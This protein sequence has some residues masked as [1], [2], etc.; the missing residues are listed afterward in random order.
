MLEYRTHYILIMQR[1]NEII[2]NFKSTDALHD[3]L[4][5]VVSMFYKTIRYVKICE[6][7]D[8]DSRNLSS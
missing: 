1:F 8:K 5:A 7:K 3:L 4:I 2:L 6:S